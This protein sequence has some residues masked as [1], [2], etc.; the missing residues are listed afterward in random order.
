[1]SVVVIVS[2]FLAFTVTFDAVVTFTVG[3]TMGCVY[4]FQVQQA[5]G[6]SYRGCRVNEFL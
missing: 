2:V 1:M 5:F 4:V 6:D 3:P